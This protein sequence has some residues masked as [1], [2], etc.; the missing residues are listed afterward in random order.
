[1][2]KMKRFD[3]IVF[4]Q[5]D[6]NGN[7]WLSIGYLASVLTEGNF[8]C[9]V[10]F[11]LKEEIDCAV[12]LV[13]AENPIAV[14]IPVLQYNFY[15]CIAFCKKL[16]ARSPETK[17]ILGNKDATC[18]HEYL[19]TNYNKYIDAISLGEGEDTILQFCQCIINNIPFKACPGL[20]IYT[21]N[22]VLLTEKRKLRED[23]DT[24]P[25]P[26]RKY[27]I[28]E[29]NI[30]NMLGSRGCQ[31]NC[32]FCEANTI[33]RYN[34]GSRTRQRSVNNILDEIEVL[35]RQHEIMHIN[36]LDSTFCG[37]NY[38]ALERLSELYEGIIKRNLKFQ[39]GFNIRSEQI[40]QD[41][42][43]C[44]LKLE[45]VGLVSILIGLESGNEEDLV[46]YN[47]Y[48]SLDIHNRTLNILRDNGIISGKAGIHFET[49]FINFNPYTTIQRLRQNLEFFT[50]HSLMLL[51]Y[52]MTSR[53]MISGS[54]HLYEKIYNDG[55][56]TINPS[57]PVVDPYGYNFLEGNVEHAYMMYNNYLNILGI[58]NYANVISKKK[59]YTKHFSSECVNNL[60]DIYSEY[61][62]YASNSVFLVIDAIL[63]YLD[64][65]YMDN[66]MLP[67]INKYQ[68]KLFT[69]GKEI[70]LLD[71]I[72]SKKL[73]RIKH[74]IF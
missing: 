60:D 35:S 47:K 15:T 69:I 9:H 40:N 42:V 38:Q 57:C 10:S 37:N 61:V 24:F 25:F 28:G 30:Y 67:E 12:E 52:D 11:F 4:N 59:I 19:L 48:A 68:E 55:L 27:R 33:Y 49:G 44:L 2:D 66:V 5:N 43:D 39:F 45:K 22:R 14:G 34:I 18:Y 3:F 72:M 62:S 58:K 20:A 1:M 73:Y 54:C 23:I 29:S 56:L 31:G 65:N 8:D 50:S 74:L 64:E 51:P 17:V 41:F 63:N 21:D 32:S 16:K 13:I 6:H 70:E 71:N 46:L 53:L 26:S 36:F 7:S